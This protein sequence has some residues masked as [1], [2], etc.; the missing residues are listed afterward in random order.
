MTRRKAITKTNLAAVAL[1]T[2]AILSAWAPASAEG[3]P[4]PEADTAAE[5]EAAQQPQVTTATWDVPPEVRTIDVAAAWESWG[6]VDAARYPDADT[7]ILDSVTY[8]TYN[9][10]GTSVVYDDTYEKILTEKGKRSEATSSLHFNVF[11]SDV[12]VIAAEILKPDGNVVT[13]DLKRCAQIM[14]N[15]GSM[16]SNIYD[17]DDK[18]LR[19]SYPD[20]EIGDI[21]RLAFKRVEKKARVPDVWSDYQT[22][23]STAPIL[24]YSY[25]I[26]S[27]AERPVKCNVLRDEVMGTITSS[28]GTLASDPKRTLHIWHVADVPQLFPEPDMPPAHTV[29]QRILLSTA[30]SWRDLSKW[31][32]NLCKPRLESVTDE[33]RKTVDGIV[34]E[35]GDD[36]GARVRALFTWVSQ[37]IRYMGVTTEKEAPGYEPHDVSIT[38]E[39]R[40]GVCRDKAALLVAMLRLAGI[41]GFPVLIHVGEKRDPDVPMTFFNHAIVAV[42]EKDG[43]YT[44]MDPTN[45]NARDLL[46]AYLAGKS[47]LV[48]TP[49]GETL[50]TSDDIPAS[51]N[52]VFAKSEGK[53]ADDGTLTYSTVIE[54]EGLNDNAYRGH[55]IRMNAE[56]RRLFL[57]G[58]AKSL[59]PGA[60]LESFEILPEDLR[61]TDTPLKVSFTL[62]APD[63]P[64]CGDSSVLAAL[65]FVTTEIGYVNFIT[66]STGLEKRRF[67]LETENACGA[68][69]TVSLAFESLGD[70]IAL[71]ETT[72]FRTNGVTFSQKASFDRGE[73]AAA[74]LSTTRRFEINAT[75]V[76]PEDYAGFKDQLHQVER[77]TEQRAV[78][79]P[80]PT[81]A[82]AAADRRILSRDTV[83]DV[84]DDSCWTT[85]VST[86]SEVLTY[87]G[88]KAFSEIKID[89]NPVWQEVEL[90]HASVSNENG[91]VQVIRPEEINVMDAPWVA[92][93]PRYPPGRILVVNLP[94]VEIG[95]TIRTSFRF[96][97]K[98]APFFWHNHVFQSFD[99]VE[100]DTFTLNSRDNT[101]I[102]TRMFNGDDSPLVVTNGDVES[103]FYAVERPATL[104]REDRLPDDFLYAKSIYL[105][106]GAW[107][108]YLIW[109]TAAVER[110]TQPENTRECAKKAVELTLEVNDSVD[111]V[112]AIRNFVVR[113]IRLA[114]PS[115]TDL[116][117]DPAPADTILAD[118]Y[119]NLL[120]RAI[121]LYAMLKEVG[122]EPRIVFANSSRV[123]QS[124]DAIDHPPFALPTP[125]TFDYPLV[126]VNPCPDDEEAPEVFLNDTT[127]YALLGTTRHDGM[128]ALGEP[129]DDDGGP[130]LVV[131]TPDKSFENFTM[132]ASEIDLDASG[133]AAISETT[134]YGGVDAADMRMRYEEMTPE[135]RRRHTQELAGRFAVSATA[136]AP[137]VTETDA[138][139]HRRVLKVKAPDYAVRTGDTLTLELPP[140]PTPATVRGDRRTLPLLISAA[141]TW[142]RSTKIIL[143]PET[144][145]ILM[146]PKPLNWGFNALGLG[147]TSVTVTV[148]E[149]PEDG[150]K[151]VSIF[152][153]REARGKDVADPG[154][155]SL[156]LGLQKTANAL[157]QRT[158][159][160]RLK[161]E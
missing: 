123:Y 98:K 50:R 7:V 160:I 62:T 159:V 80:G 5:A 113:N 36:A 131:N 114:G 24:R 141:N 148:S 158:L 2:L 127:Q 15:P 144:E 92:S 38:F 118:G 25:F 33:M 109:L 117:V 85:T 43:D 84:V 130:L 132:T 60:K 93:A 108:E 72:S 52:M 91:Q 81:P 143:P 71:P 122:F 74:T 128:I 83:V 121:V 110:A 51:A 120:D 53:V 8:E 86:V 13:V 56:R 138:F 49:E 77:L 147:E 39:K 20:I 30:E 106:S 100:R 135:K 42:R 59:A 17:T 12:A 107:P 16:S 137:L 99:T 41:D 139:P 161:K 129:R 157:E 146:L 9:P 104:P 112:I 133:D 125:D 61:D 134:Y 101:M 18:I 145:E 47:Y 153:G 1:A 79:A 19:I 140:T 22:F 48:A 124:V 10:D 57:E 3:E 75:T 90:L 76:A 96:V 66:G 103:C 152:E 119:G 82:D 54:F 21:V 63:F 23:E 102:Y 87:A 27:P 151:V 6:K 32:W 11:Y 69:E 116:P 29:C 94:G 34:K 31:Y 58:V 88:R 154:I 136:T 28:T 40:Y 95:S 156:L 45:E 155:Y 14:V 65:P 68:E 78:L 46:P 89:F 37:N 142:S 111:K 44:L 4:P 70:P 97:Q 149:R 64:A 55:F 126:G 26:S 35:A 115:Y 67:P 105:S 150:R 73:G